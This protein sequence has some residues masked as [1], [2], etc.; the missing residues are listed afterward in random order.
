MGDS[1]VVSLTSSQY[2][3][4]FNVNFD[5]IE[6]V[7]YIFISLWFRDT[8]AFQVSQGNYPKNSLRMA[9]I[10]RKL[11]FLGAKFVFCFGE[12]DV[13]CHL[14]SP[15]K[16][17]DFLSSYTL[18]CLNLVRAQPKHVSFLT[19]TPPSDYYEN[20]PRYP[21]RGTIS[22]RVVAQNNFCV[23]LEK[24]AQVLS[25]MFM[26]PSV[27]IIENDGILKREMTDDGCHLNEKG[28][29]LIRVFVSKALNRVL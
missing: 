20:H 18:K 5:R 22:E 23:E 25:C 1:H 4:I 6:E 7:N 29:D 14:A 10:L 17:S 27:E 12:I 9:R 19:P 16:N 21:R 24:S 8:L 2:D 3:R 13:R 11:R 26:N 28:G 15:D